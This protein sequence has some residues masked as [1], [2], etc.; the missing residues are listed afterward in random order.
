[1]K[2][3]LCLVL[4]FSVQTFLFA[5]DFPEKP[6]SFVT[7][8]AGLLQPEEKAALEIQIRNIADSSSNE[9]AVVIFPD[10]QGYEYG[11]FARTVAEKWGIGTKSRN[12][13]ILIALFM[14]ERGYSF[15]V[16]Y[17]LE[18]VLTDLSTRRIFNEYMK[19]AFRKGEYYA[20]LRDAITVTGE[21]ASGEFKFAGEYGKGDIQ[22]NDIVGIIVLLVIFVFIFIMFLA[23]RGGGG[24]SGP[25]GGLTSVLPYLILGSH[26]GRGHSSSGWGG[27]GSS[28]GGFGGFG[29]GS[30][31]GGGSSG[32]W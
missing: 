29:G 22:A 30:F 23:R 24:N 7:D 9:I 27:G 21:I 1:M 13:G 32:N 4:F 6:E 11:D 31:G 20:G 14:R 26:L 8:L 12:N 2:K 3:I 18:P 5:Q 15:Q 10:A 17:G 16:G 28:G 19:P 25:G